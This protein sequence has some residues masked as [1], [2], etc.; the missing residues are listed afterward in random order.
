M[1]EK[2][3]KKTREFVKAWSERKRRLMKALVEWFGST[4]ATTKK[5]SVGKERPDLPLPPWKM[6][7]YSD[8]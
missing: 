6:N 3:T 2:P 1:K 4:A 7:P 5:V 8:A